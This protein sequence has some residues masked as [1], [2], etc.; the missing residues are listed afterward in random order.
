MSTAIRALLPGRSADLTRHLTVFS[1]I[2]I[3]GQ[4][5]EK[6]F[7]DDCGAEGVNCI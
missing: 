3:T 5:V 4:T 7:V 6:V 1:L 2:I